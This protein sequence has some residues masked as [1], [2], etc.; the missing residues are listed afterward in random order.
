MAVPF[1]LTG[2]TAMVFKLVIA[3][4]FGM[5][6]GYTRKRYPVRMRTLALV[7]MGTTIFTVISVNWLGTGV[8]NDPARIMAQ[9]VTGIGFIGAG[10]IWKSEKGMGG[11]TTAA[12][13]WTI[14]GLGMLIGLE[15]WL[16]AF[17][18][19]VL[20]FVI[21]KAKTAERKLIG[22]KKRD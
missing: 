20:A 17:A 4:L 12:A 14:A 13:V 7:C 1:G 6:L 10:V 11:L 3:V 19:L 9:V 18:G 16:T 2:E 21:L 15:M 22:S 8:V 5:V